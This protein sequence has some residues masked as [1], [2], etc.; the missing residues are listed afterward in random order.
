MYAVEK[1]ELID[2]QDAVRWIVDG[3]GDHKGREYLPSAAILCGEIRSQQKSRKFQEKPSKSIQGK[4]PKWLIEFE[5]KS[6]KGQSV[7]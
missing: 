6:K 5:A 2:I 3:C 4:R 1:Y 7:Q